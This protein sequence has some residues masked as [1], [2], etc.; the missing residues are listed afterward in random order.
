MNLINHIYKSK[1]SL[2]GFCKILMAIKKYTAAHIK[3]T[4][5]L[6]VYMVLLYIEASH[7]S[8][9]YSSEGYINLPKKNSPK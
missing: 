3:V 4:G 2:H 5:C 6:C 9:E 8:M 1:H 7:S